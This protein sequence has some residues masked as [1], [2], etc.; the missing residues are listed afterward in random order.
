MTVP[1]LKQTV[2]GLSPW[3]PGFDLRRAHIFVE[4]KVTLK[5]VF[6]EYLGFSLS[7]SLHQCS[8]LN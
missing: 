5:E 4:N 7:A 2:A 3:K 1:S 6:S 8:K